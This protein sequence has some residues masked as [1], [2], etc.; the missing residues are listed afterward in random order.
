ME[1]NLRLNLCD[2]ALILLMSGISIRVLLDNKQVNLS[3]E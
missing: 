3:I 2:L 1:L